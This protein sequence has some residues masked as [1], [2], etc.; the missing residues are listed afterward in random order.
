[1]YCTGCPNKKPIKPRKVTWKF[2]QAGL[3]NVILKGVSEYRCPECGEL[4]YSF[5]DLFQLNSMIADI[6]LTK[7]RPLTGAEIRF[8]RKHIGYSGKYFA[9]VLGIDHTTLSRIENDQQKAGVALDRHIRASVF[10]KSPDRHY[11]LHDAILNQ[12]SDY[13]KDIVLRARKNRWIPESSVS[14]LLRFG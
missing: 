3:K 9:K 4:A 2:D 11:D 12:P 8:L 5:G 7:K 13:K 1:M 10:A 6:L 14:S